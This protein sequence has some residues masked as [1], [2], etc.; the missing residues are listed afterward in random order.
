[1]TPVPEAVGVIP[2]RYASSRLPGKPLV[3]LAGKPMILRVWE[4]ARLA[5]S[6]SRVLVATDDERIATVVRKAG[7]EAVMTSPDLPSGTDRMAAAARSIDAEIFVNIQGDEPL[8]EPDEIDSVVGILETDPAVSVGTLVKPITEA[9][10]LKSPNT[11]KVV[12]DGDGYALFFS[13]S[14]IPFCRDGSG[15]EDWIRRFGYLKHIGI[16]GFRKPFLLEFAGWP[17]GALESVER[18]EQLR[19]LERGY[20]IKTAVTRFEPVCVDTPEDVERVRIL[21]A[22]MEATKG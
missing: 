6:L 10:E 20:R 14:P 8:V 1:V 13:R 4:R 2:A 22:G 19:V 17:P 12:V 5:K 21:I 11:A 18:L 16:Y 7:G 15:P 9:E 3:D